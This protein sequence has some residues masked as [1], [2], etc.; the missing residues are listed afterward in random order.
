LTDF[1][2]AVEVLRW[3]IG[4]LLLCRFPRLPAGTSVGYEVDS[5]V[6]VVVPA[7][8]EG[9]NIADAVASITMQRPHPTE[10]VVVDDNS[11]DATAERAAAHG[12]RVVDA[13]PVPDGWLGKPHAAA[14]GVAA[15]K[16][17][18]VVFLDADVRLT[19][20]DVIARLAAVVPAHDD[21]HGRGLVTVQPSHVIAR[22]YEAL[23]AFFV[24]VS[25]MG[26]NAFTVLGR[27]ARTI[28]AFGPC[29]ATTRDAYAGVGGHAAP[30]VRGSIV[31]DVALAARY[32]ADGRPVVAFAGGDD[33]T[34]RMYPGG[35]RQLI[36]GWTK[37]IA[38]GATATRPLVLLLVVAWLS[39]CITA[40]FG[41][42]AR[43]SLI[44]ALTYAAYAA[45]VAVLLRRCGRFPRLAAALYAIPLAVFLLVFVRAIAL[46]ALGRP[47]AWKAR[48]V[49]GRAK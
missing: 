49:G 24:L 17:G 22:P 8:N 7:R 37:N 45:A 48:A 26:T 44:A 29:L 27:H 31:D 25:L 43:P 14:T 21:G 30:E 47:V 3:S 6:V 40:A 4:P 23:N 16:A 19:A 42:I 10:I 12:A 39:G 33:V 36:D 2:V 38:A 32:R 5:D 28:G 11:D 35:L 18:T 15:S 9:D 1:A 34:Y 41:V 46:R 13:G 20:P